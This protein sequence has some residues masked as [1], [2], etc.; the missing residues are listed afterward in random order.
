MA[1]STGSIVPLQLLSIFELPSGQEARA[2]SLR[3]SGYSS[4]VDNGSTSS[5]S[6]RPLTPSTPQ[7]KVITPA[8]N[9]NTQDK[10]VAPANDTQEKVVAPANDAQEKV[11]APANNDTQD[12]DHADSASVSTEREGQEEE[13]EGGGAGKGV[14]PEEE[15]E[16]EETVGKG[17]GEG[18]GVAVVQSNGGTRNVLETEVKT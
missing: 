11:V 12:K 17:T 2:E 4:S 3:K 13:G 15:G 18:G 8:N 7:D 5:N 6:G 14:E 16:G 9:N 1:V 10:A